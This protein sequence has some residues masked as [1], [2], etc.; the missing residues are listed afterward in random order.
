MLTTATGPVGLHPAQSKDDDHAL[1]AR[2]EP[3]NES[4]P[5]ARLEAAGPAEEKVEGEVLSSARLES[6][7]MDAQGIS[8]AMSVDEVLESAPG[9]VAQVTSPTRSMDGGQRQSAP[10][11][12]VQVASSASTVDAGDQSATGMDLQGTSTLTTEATSKSLPKHIEINVTVIETP[13]IITSTKFQCAI[14]SNCFS[15]EIE[16]DDHVKTHGENE[17]VI[18]LMKVMCGL[19]T[20]WERKF[21]LQ[22]QQVSAL[23]HQLHVLQVNVSKERIRPTPASSRPGTGPTAASPPAPASP[24][25]ASSPLSEPARP[26]PVR[27]SQA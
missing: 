21:D 24:P 23:Q 7:Q 12:E 10:G 18:K 8:G 25:S 14:C 1:S 2:M 16:A 9:M 26:A 4:L 6:P 17:T 19:K 15:T 11:L 3:E 27:R 13:I 20:S 22:Q 5:P